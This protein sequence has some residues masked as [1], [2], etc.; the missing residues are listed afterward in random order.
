MSLFSM[1][2]ASG[3][4]TEAAAR[5]VDLDTIMRTSGH[6]RV[7]TVRGYIQAGE[8]FKRNAAGAVGL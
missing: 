5:G 6:A 4:I 7:D 2:K 1:W 8:Q 3:L